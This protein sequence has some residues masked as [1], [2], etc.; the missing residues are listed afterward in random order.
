MTNTSTITRGSRGTVSPGTK[1]ALAVQIRNIDGKPA[2]NRTGAAEYL[3]RSPQTIDLWASPAQ[4]PTTGWPA[5]T[6]RHDGQEW[7]HLHELDDFRHTYIH[8]KETANR[9]PPV[10]SSG[11]PDELIT[12]VQF[13]ELINVTAG[14]W[15]RY[16]ADSRA[17]WDAGRDGYLPR[18][19]HEEPGRGGIQRSWRRR[20]ATDWANARVGKTAATGRPTS[21][22]D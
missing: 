21:S 20:R 14:T 10:R 8:P 12:A 3:H 17:D 9:P 1:G 19:D 18:P 6:A 13:R 7:Y 15:G 22:P 2:T 11:D 16:V 4:R 5:A